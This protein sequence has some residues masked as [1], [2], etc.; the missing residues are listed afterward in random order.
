MTTRS[1][2][3]TVHFR[4]SFRIKGIDRQLPAGAYEVADS[5]FITIAVLRDAHWKKFCIAMDLQHLAD[6]ERFRTNAAR[7]ANRAELDGIIVPLL[8]AEPAE[9][10][11]ERLRRADILCGPINTLADV[12]GDPAIAAHLPLIDPGLPGVARVMG[13][14]IRF[15]G[16]YFTADKPPP[17]KGQ[18]TRE[19]LSELGFSSSEIAAHVQAGSAFLAA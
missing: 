4:H 9:V 3:E 13:T 15:N 17:G 1:R 11:L 7:T 14:P 19:I 8:K 12:A 18:H 2:R 16:A 6:D 10:W 5:R